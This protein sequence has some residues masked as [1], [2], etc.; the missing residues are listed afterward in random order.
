M[1]LNTYQIIK[2]TI[3]VTHYEEN[4]DSSNLNKYNSNKDKGIKAEH[5]FEE[6]WNPEIEKVIDR[7][8]HNRNVINLK[9]LEN[10][11]NKINK[12]F[13]D[14]GNGIMSF[15]EENNIYKES[16]DVTNII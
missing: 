6:H 11:V 12:Y 10:A 2:E 7:I 1:F 16:T 15:W 14:A 5:F 9:M 4:Q 8:I 3:I 13:S